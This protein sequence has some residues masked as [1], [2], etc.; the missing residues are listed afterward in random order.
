MGDN[1]SVN[2]V[3]TTPIVF[4]MPRSMISSTFSIP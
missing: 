1:A 4:C 2:I 3:A